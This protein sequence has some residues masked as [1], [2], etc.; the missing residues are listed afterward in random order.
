VI[1]GAEFAAP[2]VHA[3]D[4]GSAYPFPAKTE[5]PDIAS[6]RARH[7]AA[8]EALLAAGRALIVGAGPSG[9]ELAGEIKAVFPD[10]HVTIADRSD[11]ILVGPYDQALR[12]EL[13]RQLDALGVELRLGAAISELP[14][15]PPATLGQ[16]LEPHARFRRRCLQPHGSQ[17]AIR[18]PLT[19]HG[20]TVV[21]GVQMPFASCEK[22]RWGAPCSLRQGL[23][24]V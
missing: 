6:A 13:R 7:R 19:A 15:A 9:L 3:V 20:I 22:E 18:R 23:S 4:R 12:D 10:K 5:E 21:C 8:H 16:A 2:D 11:D 17:L 1:A 24:D 14:T